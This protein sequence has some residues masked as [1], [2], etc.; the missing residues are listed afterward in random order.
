MLTCLCD[1]LYG[2]VGIATVR[3]LR[4]VGCEV[5]FDDAQTCCGQPPFNAGD[6]EASRQVARHCRR[7]FG[8]GDGIPLVTPSGSCAA[9]LHE[10]YEMLFPGEVPDFESYEL[11]QFLYHVLGLRAWPAEKPYARKVALHKGCHGRGLGLRDEHE[12]LLASVPGLEIVPFDQP[13]QCCGF[14][15]AFSATFGKVSQGIGEEKLR[16]V[17][18]AGPDELASTDMGCLVH[19]NGLIERSGKRL[20]TRHFSEILAETIA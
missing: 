17:R 8:K 12:T 16:N 18:A 10:G 9:M 5:L 2:E 19:L 15:G 1:A 6:W 11:G 7:V 4:H 20:R 13:E 14:G 3:V